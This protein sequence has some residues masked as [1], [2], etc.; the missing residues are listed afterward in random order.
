MDNRSPFE[1][2]KDEVEYAYIV[3]ATMD[4]ELEEGNDDQKLESLDE[5]ED[6]INSLLE[7]EDYLKE[8]FEEIGL[9]RV[10]CEVSNI[11]VDNVTI[12]FGISLK[13]KEKDVVLQD[14]KSDIVEFMKCLDSNIENNVSVC[15]LG[16]FED[17]RDDYEPAT[18]ILKA[19]DKLKLNV[20]KQPKLQESKYKELDSKLDELIKLD[21]TD[22]EFNDF[23][24]SA[25]EL[26]DEEL[27][28]KEYTELLYKAQDTR[29]IE[30]ID[31][32]SIDK[33][34][35]SEGK[36]TFKNN[37]SV[38]NILL[39]DDGDVQVYEN[40]NL[41]E[42][43]PFSKK[44]VVSECYNLTSQNYLLE[45]PKIDLE[46]AK[47]E[48]DNAH[49]QVDEIA[50]SKEELENK[51]A[52]ILEESAQE[53]MSELPES[54]FVTRKLSATQ[55]KGLTEQDFVSALTPEQVE[56]INKLGLKPQDI[57]YGLKDLI[58]VDM[59]SVEGPI[60]DIATYINTI[61][62]VMEV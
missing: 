3:S 62:N 59:K 54:E 15:G 48:L 28:S 44:R 43:Y 45:S 46:K 49:K 16:G 27:T 1:R 30:S 4:I 2:Y 24:E 60:I 23:L 18:I 29:K 35:V 41:I 31:L 52:N 58:T 39:T 20:E 57:Y 8:S 56:Y 32:K 36:L 10:Y 26:V 25:A 6:Q 22:E 51:I 47:E 19:K 9:G 17:P 11:D 37:G 40:N 34:L 14:I 13:D 5:F 38:K 33:K 61:K 42:S 55:F 53:E 12:K 21:A 50:K 7:N